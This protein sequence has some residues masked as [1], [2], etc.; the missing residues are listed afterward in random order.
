M[1]KG[2]VRDWP[3]VQAA[4]K[5]DD[6]ADAYLRRFYE[7]ATIGAFYGPAENGGRV[8]YNDDMTGFAYQRV[9]AKLDQVLDRLRDHRDDPQAPCI[10]V[11]ST[12]VDTALPGFRR[13]N[14]VDLGEFD[15][16]V[17]IW[18]GN[19][20]SVAAHHDVPD[21]L[22]C[23]VAG[24]RRFTL[25]PPGQLGN[26]YIGPLDFTPAGQSIS[27]V[28]FENPDY[29]RYPRFRDALA[30][31]RVADMEPGDALFLPSMWWHHVRARDD[32]NVLIN[33]W[34]RRSPAWMGNPT[35]VLT[36][37]V[38]SLRDLPRA[39][40][41][42]WRAV[43]EHYVFGADDDTAAHIPGHVRGMLAPLDETIA[44]RMR[45]DLL[46]KLNR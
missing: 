40:R 2:L 8:F 6:A 28:D 43:F 14:D 42:A 26:L 29:E 44:R 31:A 39:Q 46:N 21:N 23:C 7:G 24:R 17:S 37:A 19:R 1:L 12:T 10:Y 9:M 15:A 18:L 27:L 13:E 30:H 41:D 33:S 3:F 22:A 4:L 11:G 34:W 25:F 16:L 32:L 36:H 45:A 20:T 38:L 35:D 5:S